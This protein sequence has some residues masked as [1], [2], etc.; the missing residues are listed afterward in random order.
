MNRYTQCIL[1]FAGLAACFALVGA[2]G[3]DDT[4]QPKPA[5]PPRGAIILF[6]G[7]DTSAWK[8]RNGKEPIEWT[9]ADGTMEVKPGTSDILTKQDFG[10]Y[11]LHVEFATPLMP[12]K[13][14]QERG[15]SGC[16]QHGRY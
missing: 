7:K 4:K 14:S 15:N 12:D 2:A 1:R 13:K 3:A 16:Y 9:V 8:H 11:Q 6:N 10:D 5:K